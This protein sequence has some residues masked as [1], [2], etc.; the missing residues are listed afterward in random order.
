MGDHKITEDVIPSPE[1]PTKKNK[2][3]FAC[4]I[5]ASMTSILLGYADLSHESSGTYWSDE[6]SSDIHPTRPQNQRRT[7]GGPDGNHQPLLPIRLGRLRPNIRLDR[8]PLHNSPS[9]SHLLHSH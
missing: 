5:L 9:R 6:W 8:P 4:A 3:A 7:S 1:K 2:Y